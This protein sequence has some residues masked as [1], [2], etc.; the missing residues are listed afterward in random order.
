MKIATYMFNGV[1]R[2]GMVSPGQQRV[3]PFASS[4]EQAGSMLGL[5]ES[6]ASGSDY[7]PLLEAESVALN[8]VLLQ[9]PI[10]HPRRN[11]W[12][13][14]R[15]YHAHARELA[16]SVFQASNSKTDE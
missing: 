8:E 4:P 9:A 2:I 11:L 7:P 6:R 16:A 13:V 5:I 1:R 10:P 15:N 14:G 3:T 12:C